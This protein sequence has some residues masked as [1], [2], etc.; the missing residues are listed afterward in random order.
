MN[1]RDIARI[2]GVAVSTVSRVMNNHQDVGPE[3]RERILKVMEET[4]YIPNSNARNLKR[5]SS[6][7]V[8]V[9]IKGRY[10]PFFLRMIEAIENEITNRNYSMILHYNHDSANDIEAAVELIKEKRLE[11]LICLGGNF[12]QIDDSYLLNLKTPLVLASSDLEGSTAYNDFSSVGIANEAA[13]YGAIK[14]LID[15]GHRKIGLISSDETDICI[16]TLRKKG[17]LKALQDNGIE[18]DPGLIESGQYTF[19]SGYQVAQEILNRRPDLTAFF[20]IS[21]IMAIGAMRAIHERGLRIPEDISVV[22]F[23]GL[24]Y[25]AYCHPT[26]T[27]IQQPIEEIGIKSAELLFSLIDKKSENQH[28]IL[29]TELIERNSTKRI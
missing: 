3:T 9:M 27:T 29:E 17:Y 11:G 7:S 10:N 16:G 23:D 18:E 14:H 15:R 25:A 28:L 1:I 19:E 13:A 12:N 22:G 6:A 5:T 21:D 4:G 2:A 24:D 8:G 26:L 20:V